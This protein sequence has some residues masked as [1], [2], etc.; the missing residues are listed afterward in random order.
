MNGT[1]QFQQFIRTSSKSRKGFR[2][3]QR[4]KSFNESLEDKLATY[5]AYSSTLYSNIAEMQPTEYPILFMFYALAGVK[6][7]CKSVY[8]GLD[9]HSYPPRYG[10]YISHTLLFK[11]TEKFSPIEIYEKA[12]WKTGEQVAKEDNGP[13]PEYI[14]DLSVTIHPDFVD[15]KWFNWLACP[16]DDLVNRHFMT[17][18]KAMFVAAIDAI[19]NRKQLII[20]DTKEMLLNWAMTLL[21]ALPLDFVFNNLYIASFA[22]SNIPLDICK[23]LCIEKEN[24]ERIKR[25]APEA[26]ILNVEKIVLPSS[27]SLFATALLE[28]IVD[29]DFEK[30]RK[31]VFPK[32]IETGTYKINDFNK[33]TL[34]YTSLKEISGMLEEEFKSFLKTVIERPDYIDYVFQE[35]K[36][37]QATDK[38]PVLW[39]EL[40]KS[41]SISTDNLEGYKSIA[42]YTVPNVTDEIWLSFEKKIIE[43][44]KFET[45][46]EICN[47]YDIVK[48]KSENKDAFYYDLI[49]LK[50]KN[51]ATYKI[52]NEGIKSIRNIIT[53]FSAAQQKEIEATENY[54]RIYDEIKAVDTIEEKYA[55][56]LK[57]HLPEAGWEIKNIKSILPSITWKDFFNLLSI[58]KPLLSDPFNIELIS[59]KL[60]E[61]ELAHFI[62]LENYQKDT[63]GFYKLY[64]MLS[65]DNKSIFTQ[66][67]PKE[68][69][70]IITSK[71][72]SNAVTNKP[73][74]SEV[75]QNKMVVNSNALHKQV[76]LDYD[77]LKEFITTPWTWN[78]WKPLFE[79]LNDQQKQILPAILSNFW[80]AEKKEE[81]SSAGSESFF[82]GWQINA[83]LL[84]YVFVI[85]EDHK[86]QLIELNKNIQLSWKSYD[87]ILATLSVTDQ[88]VNSTF[89]L[90]FNPSNKMQK[91]PV[92]H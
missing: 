81:K 31:I 67:S 58:N 65:P 49:M 21:Q 39:D 52:A 89:E 47:F 87:F 72:Q 44:I 29:N 60:P 50:I 24:V 4:S 64:E 9:L 63:E 40:K 36:D 54:L 48:I 20:V 22:I 13:V 91:G 5:G 68:I 28:A 70:K 16:S 10:N 6:I 35:I 43:E 69:Q 83:V 2:T 3:Y 45:I 61:R 82:I 18:R 17:E 51:S 27:T 59:D 46:N 34:I 14:D 73:I 15:T 79:Q 86:E 80:V 85:L 11:G 1:V 53:I 26:V 30:F 42:A 84:Y 25:Y 55:V 66:Y 71:Q 74:E 57:N 7:I 77:G 41:K 23:V 92:W 62:I 88:T 32:V 33:E 37:Q 12:S 78:N 90:F 8:L 56:I 75:S 19:I 76:T 38:Y